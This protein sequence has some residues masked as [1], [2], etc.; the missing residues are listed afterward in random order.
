MTSMA[1]LSG[2]TGRVPIVLIAFNR[3]EATRRVLERIK[4]A[5]PPE[6]FVIMDAAREHVPSD[7]ERCL[8]V[9]QIISSVDWCPKIHT[10]YA[11]KNMGCRNRLSTGITAVFEETPEAIFLEDDCLPDPSFFRYCE[12]LLERYRDDERIM[13]I[14]GT[15]WQYGWPVSA[16]YFGS[17]FAHVWGWA[18]WR[19]A[20]NRYDVAMKDWP[21]CRQDAAFFDLEA[22]EYRNYWTRIFDMVSRGEIES[23]AFQWTFAHMRHRGI[24]IA[25]C[26]NLVEN[27]GFGSDATNTRSVPQWLF[28][29]AVAMQHPLCHPAR[30]I[31][32]DDAD[33]R[34]FLCN[35]R[36]RPPQL[37]FWLPRWMESIHKRMPGWKVR[38]EM[39]QRIWPR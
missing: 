8:E 18:S 16:S 33:R 3:P 29:K 26:V 38:H 31:Y 23:W 6:L 17:R 27:I 28:Q 39:I 36:L 32:D 12:E 34:T 30:L 4:H 15:N 19:R 20:W 1:T 24:S 11:S 5:S 10:I 7:R 13:S 37:P 2:Q 21:T 35:N 22:P 9:Q 25:P 14:G